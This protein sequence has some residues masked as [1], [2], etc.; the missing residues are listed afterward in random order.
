MEGLWANTITQDL[1][2]INESIPSTSKINTIKENKNLETKSVDD[3]DSSIGKDIPD[4]Q[5]LT[6]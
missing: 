6:K 3:S 4:R 1:E 2:K 5:K